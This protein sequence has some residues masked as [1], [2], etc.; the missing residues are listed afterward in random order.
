MKFKIC[1]LLFLLSTLGLLQS[2]CASDSS[3]GDHEQVRVLQ[4]SIN[5]NCTLPECK[6]DLSVVYVRSSRYKNDNTIKSGPDLHFILSTF[7]GSPA[8]FVTSAKNNSYPNISWSDLQNNQPH[9]IQFM[10]DGKPARDNTIGVMISKIFFWLDN[11][12]AEANYVPGKSQVKELDLKGKWQNVTVLDQTKDNVHVQYD[13]NDTENN[14]KISIRFM[15]TSA[16]QKYVDLP[17]LMLTPKAVHSQLT[18]EGFDKIF[19]ENATKRLGMELA[20]ITK[21]K[22]VKGKENGDP[23]TSFDD[24][25][26][27][28][29]FIVSCCLFNRNF[30]TLN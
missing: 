24:E 20:V 3:L 16:T 12:Q 26:S 11:E 27:P 9:S 15:I 28:G 21:G 4:S 1:A 13:L 6:Q 7:G 19:S 30:T 2:A 29:M 10:A 25:Y 8:Y 23:Q 14:G 22:L 18:I 5:E 17:S